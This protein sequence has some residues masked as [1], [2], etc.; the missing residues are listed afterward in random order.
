VC[1][2][3]CTR[4]DEELLWSYRRDGK[5]AGRNHAFIWRT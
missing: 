5:R 2:P 4:C 1:V 3:G